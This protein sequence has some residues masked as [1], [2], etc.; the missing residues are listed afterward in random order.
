MRELLK[1]ECATNPVCQFLTF[2]LDANSTND[3]VQ[4]IFIVPPNRVFVSECVSVFCVQIIDM[5]TDAFK[6]DIAT[7]YRYEE[8]VKNVT[9][10]FMKNGKWEI[11]DGKVSIYKGLFEYFRLQLCDRFFQPFVVFKAVFQE[12]DTIDIALINNLGE[13]HPEFTFF[14]RLEGN[15]YEKEYVK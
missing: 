10:L 4:T 5:P 15:L 2:K 6:Y 9:F 1:I 13:T 11:K 14:V 8:V 7:T 12:N 3:M